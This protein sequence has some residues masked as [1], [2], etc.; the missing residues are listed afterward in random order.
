MRYEC[1]QFTGG[2]TGYGLFHGV[3]VAVLG[4]SLRTGGRTKGQS[5]DAGLQGCTGPR[6]QFVGFQPTHLR[7]EESRVQRSLQAHRNALKSQCSDG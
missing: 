2:S 3:L 1:L 7:L 6:T 4:C 5:I